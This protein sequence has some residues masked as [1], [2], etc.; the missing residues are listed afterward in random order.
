MGSCH[1][2]KMHIA[3][4][5]ASPQSLVFKLPCHMV[6]SPNQHMVFYMNYHVTKVF[7]NFRVLFF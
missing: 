6:L 1:V 5:I 3:E 4:A 7:P 2:I